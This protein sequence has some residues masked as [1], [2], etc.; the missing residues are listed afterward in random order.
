MMY[1]M[2]KKNIDQLL[3]VLALD[4][5]VDVHH[6]GQQVSN[7]IILKPLPFPRRGSM[8][9]PMQVGTRP[10]FHA[11]NSSCCGTTISQLGIQWERGHRASNI[12]TL[13]HWAI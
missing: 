3:D 8:C 6:G 7:I 12:K 9:D 2:T 4:L 5:I 1:H 11:C 10:Q 13:G